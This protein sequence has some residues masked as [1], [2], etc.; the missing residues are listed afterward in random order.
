MTE[1][2]RLEDQLRPEDLLAFGAAQ[3]ARIVKQVRGSRGYLL[4]AVAFS[5]VIF[6]VGLFTAQELPIR[7]GRPIAYPEL[8]A[9]AGLSFLTTLAF[10]LMARRRATSVLRERVAALNA[11]NFGPRI[12]T[13]NA[14]R[15][16]VQFDKSGTW[17]AWSEFKELTEHETLVVVWR[18]NLD[19][20]I[21]TKR[22]FG[23]AADL[24]TFMVAARAWIAQSDS[25]GGL[26]P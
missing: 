23:S 7:T 3:R 6:A 17:R 10:V 22:A 9:G 13:L 1:F 2:M 12:L 26:L 8:C 19:G 20:L 18:N 5:M 14:E 11:E 24:E 21:V 4:P 25:S 15:V 16:E